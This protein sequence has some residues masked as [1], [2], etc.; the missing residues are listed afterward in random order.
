MGGPLAISRARATAGI[1]AAPDCWQSYRL[2]GK[3]GV[4]NAYVYRFR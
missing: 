1:K 3:A 4:V 2:N